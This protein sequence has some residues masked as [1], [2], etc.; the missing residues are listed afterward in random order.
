YR[1]KFYLMGSAARRLAA[2]DDD[3]VEAL[4]G[5]EATDTSSQLGKT[6][7]HVLADLRGRPA[8]AVVMWTDGITTEGQ[9]LGETAEYALR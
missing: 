3:L 7:R 4:R 2:E 1:L 5:V 8:A 9:T 6:L